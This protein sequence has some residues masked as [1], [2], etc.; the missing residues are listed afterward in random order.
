MNAG[1]YGSAFDSVLVLLP[2]SENS[3][4]GIALLSDLSAFDAYMIQVK[5]KSKLP[6][7]LCSCVSDEIRQDVGNR[8][9]AAG[10]N[11]LAIKKELLETV[12]TP[13][14]VAHCNFN[15]ILTTFSNNDT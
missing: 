7:I 14:L 6:Q 12:F 13:F 5:L 8:L 15:E 9:E 11:F 1:A 4:K 10:I 2:G 3:K